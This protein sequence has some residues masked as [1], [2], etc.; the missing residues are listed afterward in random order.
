MKNKNKYI[1]FSVFVILFVFVVYFI[2]KKSS[3]LA[4]TENQKESVMEIMQEN[5]NSLTGAILIPEYNE[6]NLVDSEQQLKP[7]REIK[8]TIFPEEVFDKDFDFESLTSSIG[9]QEYGHYAKMDISFLDTIKEGDTLDFDLKVGK[10]FVRVEKKELHEGGASLT[11]RSEYHNGYMLWTRE[12]EYEALYGRFY[13]SSTDGIYETVEGNFNLKGELIY[14]DAD[15][16][17]KETQKRL[18]EENIRLIY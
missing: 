15:T 8:Y 9:Y 7:E 16:K 1:I 2:A 10:Y 6:E 18:K 11:L 17:H 5:K 4:I 12:S 13:I 14:V 3:D